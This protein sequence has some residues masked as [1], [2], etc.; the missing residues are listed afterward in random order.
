VRECEDE[1]CGL[2][3]PISGEIAGSDDYGC[4]RY[5]A[6]SEH[7]M[8]TVDNVTEHASNEE[9][10]RGLRTTDCAGLNAEC[11]KDMSGSIAE[12]SCSDDLALEIAK[13]DL[14]VNPLSPLASSRHQ[15]ECVC[16]N[17]TADQ[18]SLTVFKGCADDNGKSE[19]SGYILRG[20]DITVDDSSQR[21]SSVDDRD[22]RLQCNVIS[23]EVHGVADNNL[24]S[25]AV[26]DTSYG[27][28]D[29]RLCQTEAACHSDSVNDCSDDVR[30]IS[31]VDEHFQFM[32]VTSGVCDK[33]VSFNGDDTTV[34]PDCSDGSQTSA[35]NRG[36]SSSGPVD[37]ELESSSK[38]DS[39]LECRGSRGSIERFLAPSVA[40]SKTIATPVED[41]GFAKV[42]GYVS[43][44][45]VM[46][47]EGACEYNG[48]LQ[49]SPS[50]K[51]VDGKGDLSNV[52]SDVCA[53]VDKKVKIANESEPEPVVMR[54]EN[55]RARTRTSR[56]N[57]LLGLSKPSVILSESH[58]MSQSSETVG[59]CTLPAGSPQ[60][61][62]QT[63]AMFGLCRPRQRPVLSPTLPAKSRPNSL[64]LPQRPT[65]W[66]PAPA[67]Q[68]PSVSTSKRPCSLN[69]A[70]G[71]SQE[72]VP[73]NSGPT[74]TKCRRRTLAGGLRCGLE[75]ESGVVLAS[76]VS[77]SATEPCTAL[78]SSLLTPPQ[79]V[80]APASVG[81][82]ASS[83]QVEP[84]PSR[85]ALPPQLSSSQPHSEVLSI[86][87]AME[88]PASLTSATVNTSIS[89]LGRVA[90]VWVPDANAPRCMHCDCR[91]TFTRRRHHCRACGK[92]TSPMWSPN[93]CVH[94]HDCRD[95]TSPPLL[96]RFLPSPSATFPLFNGGS[97]VL[98]P[99]KFWY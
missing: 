71:L 77:P 62:D 42:P 90:P 5:I 63:D 24:C 30:L 65:S 95:T 91:F 48:I 20:S 80:A 98:T 14:S 86:S 6:R 9:T 29:G 35:T 84:T 33:V 10:A 38:T 39:V 74:E 69:L 70:M 83:E 16:Q 58:R 56:P 57:S 1:R 59:A 40:V 25:T 27:A 13:A 17:V 88:A 97:G 31:S 81:D 8:C 26:E 37:L 28:A 60:S 15:S 4:Q 61:S 18:N 45:A 43:E 3:R 96:S 85:S 78:P 49:D 82:V 68:P 19:Y 54:A 79:Q 51:H 34:L 66:S 22:R 55:A 36:N 44:L 46:E 94:P 93:S 67:L 21:N 89:D 76:A 7:K 87:S 50:T 72:T 11:G 23:V 52:D 53:A 73:R 32:N 41:P 2:T 75:A 47:E 12:H 64:S 92:V 99:R